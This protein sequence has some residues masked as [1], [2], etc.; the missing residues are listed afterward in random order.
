MMSCTNGCQQDGGHLQYEQSPNQDLTFVNVKTEV[1]D[2]GYL[3]ASTTLSQDQDPEPESPEMSRKRKRKLPAKFSDD[4][5]MESV[6]KSL[7]TPDRRTA[8]TKAS[9]TVTT[10]SSG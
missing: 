1:Q 9:S 6:T 7:T 3:N 8:S 2:T 5:E 10:S 4:F